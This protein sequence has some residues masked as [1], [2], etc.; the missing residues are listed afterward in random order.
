M[1][2]RQPQLPAIAEHSPNQQRPQQA[3]LGAT[4]SACLY[5]YSGC[6]S[7]TRTRNP[8]ADL[9]PA[10]ADFAEL[11]ATDALPHD[12]RSA[13]R[14]ATVLIAEVA[15]TC[16]ASRFR[17]SHCFA[18]LLQAAP[19]QVGQR[20]ACIALSLE[21]LSTGLRQRRISASNARSNSGSARA[22]DEIGETLFF[23]LK[24]RSASHRSRGTACRQTTLYSVS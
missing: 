15:K 21:C 4:N 23:T 14:H 12:A 5:H 9:G 24:H 8:H 2:R 13:C 20:C 19:S 11:R 6:E 22:F 16:V 17:S 1:G 3:P 7:L 10:H 18:N